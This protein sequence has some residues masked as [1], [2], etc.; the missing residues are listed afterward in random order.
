MDVPPP[1][2]SAFEGMDIGLSYKTVKKGVAMSNVIG[3]VVDKFLRKTFGLQTE[4]E[5]REGVVINGKYQN[6]ITRDFSSM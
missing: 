6:E 2:P 1:L 4:P 3:K 5:G